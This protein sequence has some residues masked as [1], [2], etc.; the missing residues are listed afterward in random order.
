MQVPLQGQPPSQMPATPEHATAV[1]ATAAADFTAGN[2]ASKPKLG[3]L[4]SNS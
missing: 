3:S 4:K 1:V 2:R